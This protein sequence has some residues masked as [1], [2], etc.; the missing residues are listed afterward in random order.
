ML[1]EEKK[2]DE[3]NKTLQCEEFPQWTKTLEKENKEDGTTQHT[4]FLLVLI[5]QE[6][7]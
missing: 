5:V 7:V 1:G 2:K 3:A 6:E 4:N